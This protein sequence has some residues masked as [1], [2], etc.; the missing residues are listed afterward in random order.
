M[1]EFSVG[2]LELTPLVLSAPD[3]AALRAL[4]ATLADE[5]RAAG[6]LGELAADR[7]ARDAAERH[8]AVVLAADRTRLLDGLDALSSGRTAPSLVTGA[9]PSARR[10]VLVFPGAG[11][12]W[13]GM[14]RAL[15]DA[16]PPFARRLNAC[17]RALGSP[18]EVPDDGVDVVQ[19][20]LFAVMVSLAELWRSFGVEP[21]AVLAQCIGEPAGAYAGSALSLRD[22]A[23]A[24]TAM[25]EAQ[26]GVAALGDMAAVRL[27]APA[28]AAKLK[29]WGGRLWVAGVNAPEWTLV[30][31]DRAARD[32]LL[33]ALDDEG[34]FA[35]A[36]R[37]GAPTHTVRLD[38]ARTAMLD[39]LAAIT[40]RVGRVPFHSA[41]TGT[42]TDGALLDAGHW[43]RCVREPVRFEEATRSA[44]ADGPAALI[45]SAPHPSLL[46]AMRDTV[47]AAGADAVV[48]GSVDRDDGGLDQFTRSVAQAYCHGVAVDWARALA[49]AAP[50]AHATVHA[51]P[52]P[53]EPVRAATKPAATEA[54]ATERAATER[55]VAEPAVAEPAATEPAATEPAATEPAAT[56]PAAT[57]PAVTEPAASE[58]AMAEPAATEP[59][60]TEPAATE[61][62]EIGPAVAER[63]ATERVGD[64]ADGPGEPIAILGMACRFPG[65]IETPEQLWDAVIE[66][67]DLIGGLP[68]DRGWDTRK[69]YEPDSGKPGTSYTKEGGFLT[70]AAEFDAELFG[71]SPRE[72][73][74]MHPQQRILLEIAWEACER[75]GVD[76]LSLRETDTGVFIGAFAT[77]Y[78]PRMHEAGAGSSGYM[79]TGGTLSVLS[80]RIAYALGLMGPAMTID[81]ACSSSLTSVHQAVASLRSGECS[82][83]FA[84]GASVLG[85]PG[86][87]VDFSRQQALSHDGHSRAFSADAD[88]FGMA[89]GA[90]MLLL[91][92]LSDARRLGRPVLGV[93]R[94]SALSQDGASE[95]LAVPDAGAQEL[96]VRRALED[97]GLTAGDIDLVEAHGTGTKVGDPI[98]ARS[99]LAAYGPAGHPVFLGSVKSNIGHSMAAAGVAGVIKAV[100]ALRH[101][102][103]P[104]TLHAERLNPDVDWSRGDVRVLRENRDW[105][106]T[107]RVRR[108]AVSAYGISGT[109][110]HLVLEQ[111]PSER[112]AER[113]PEDVPALPWVLTARSPAALRAQAERLLRYVRENPGARAADVGWTLATSRARLEHRGVIV[114]DR[115]EL[116]DGLAALAAGTDAPQL[117]RGAD[118]HDAHNVF[119]FPGQGSQW[120]GMAAELLE[121]SPVFARRIAE[122][123]EALA[124][125]IDWSLTDVLRAG[126]PDDAGTDVVQPALF[127]VMVSLAA[128][129]EDHGVVPDAVLGHSQGEMAAAVVAGALSLA[130]AARVVALRARA[131]RVLA[132]TGAMA[133]VALPPDAA[134][135]RLDER[136]SVAAING[137]AEVVVSGDTDAVASLLE[138][139]EA[140]GVWARRIAVDFA[141]HS[142]HVERLRDRLLDDLDGVRPKT[143]DVPFYST[144]TGE[145]LD[146]E[147]LDAEYWFTNLRSPVR[148]DPALR[149]ALAAGHRTLIEISPHPILTMGMQ[150]IID[151]AG[152]DA[153]ALGTLRRGDGG[154]RRFRLAVAEADAHGVAAD[155]SRAFAGTAPRLL[156]LPTYAFQHRRYWLD[157]DA[158]GAAGLSTAGLEDAGHPLLG[159]AT[160]L[161]GSQVL[162]LTGSVS[163]R[164]HPFLADHAVHDAVVFPGTAF[165]EV[166]LQAADR[167]G[168]D[169]VEELILET[170]LVIPADEP[171]RL[172][173]TVDEDGTLE[174][175][176]RPESA[177]EWTRHATG[178]A[179]DPPPSDTDD[180]TAWPPSGAEPVPLDGFYD[181]VAERGYQYGPA[182]RNL[183]AAW[184]RGDEVFAEIAL[185]GDAETEAYALHPALLDAALQGTLLDAADGLRMPLSWQD[186]RLHA[187]G[188]TALRARLART[189]PDTFEVTVADA[190]GRP[191]LTVRSLALRTVERLRTTGAGGLFRLDWP[192]V[193][194][195]DRTAPDA[196]TWALVGDEE[197][198]GVLPGS[199]AVFPDVA[200]L[201]ASGAPDVAVL[202]C[203]RSGAHET[204]GHVLSELREWLRDEPPGVLVVLTRG[205]V[206]VHPRDAVTDLAQAAVWG[207]VRGAQPEHQ[208]RLVLIDLDEETSVASALD[209][210][211]PQIALR[212]GALHV[213]RL[214]PAKPGDAPDERP[215]RLDL[216]PGDP[217]SLRIVPADETPLGP[218]E[219]RVAVRAAGLNFRDVAVAGGLVER[220]EVWPLLG[221]DGAGVV[222]ATGPGV[223]DVAPGD[224]VAGA[225]TGTTA[226]ASTAVTD[227][228]LVVPIPDDWTFPEAA[229]VPVAFLTAWY[230]LADLAAL[231]PGEAVL[232]HAATGGVG[233]AAVQIAR[234]LGAE[235]FATASPAKHPALRALGLD[236]AHIASSRSTAFEQHFRATA[237]NVDVVLNCL[238]GDVIDAGLRLLAPGGRFVELGRTEL[239]D[240]DAVAREHPGVSYAAFDLGLLDP[241]RLHALFGDLRG[242]FEQDVLRPLPFTAWDVRDAREAFEHM[243]RAGHV[244]KIVLTVPRRPDPAGTVLIT[245]GTGALGALTARH[246]VTEHGLRHLL[247]VGRRGPD[248][249]GAEDLRAEL[250]ALG[251]EVTI[252]A[253]DA[254]DPA[255]LRRLLDGIPAEHPLTAVVHAAAVTD[256]G[257]V[258]ALTPG[259]IDRVL[260]P[261]ADAALNLHRLT[262]GSDLAA[263]VLY[264]SVASVVSTGGQA[265]YSAA[266]AFLD[267]LALRRGQHGL[268][269]T[270]VAWGL[271]ERASELTGRLADTDRARLAQNGQLPLSDRDGLALLDAALADGGP[272]FVGARLDAGALAG[273]P[274]DGVPA[275]L[276]RLVRPARAKAST[277]P[278]ET[279]PAPLGERLA[280]LPADDRVRELL[281]VVRAQ[282]ASVLGHSRADEID[283][284]RR[285]R[286]MGFDSL[287]AVQLRNHMNRLTELKL[288]TTLVFD[289]PT[290]LALAREI[291]VRLAERS[292][293]PAPA[294]DGTARLRRLGDEKVDPDE[295]VA[296]LREILGARESG[297]DNGDLA[298][299]PVRLSTGDAVP[300]LFCLPSILAPAE[301]DQY[302]EFAR[303][304]RGHR[305][306]LALT[307][308]G[309]SDGEPLPAT[310]D[311]FGRAA[312]RA[313]LAEA[314]D[315]PFVL[316][317]HSS[318]A[319]L[320]HAVAE[321]CEKD[322]RSPAGLVLLDPVDIGWNDLRAMVGTADRLWARMDLL[323]LLDDANVSAMMRY[324][325]LFGEWTPGALSCPV[326]ALRAEESMPGA[327]AGWARP[328]R[329]DRTPGDHL[330]MMTTRAATTARAAETWLRDPA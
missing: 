83:A 31:G 258:T 187:V 44:L 7:A 249:P 233:L 21:A 17:E 297:G 95:G 322:G 261:K 48:L 103:L 264:S 271:W 13:P 300:R 310:V 117:V 87:L 78:G 160:D 81:T 18:P 104:K 199:P 231:R 193:P 147:A 94:G 86:L 57:E 265:N 155:W 85:T 105:P 130:D 259:Q 326:L 189:G 153:V 293:G 112:P 164:T 54:A 262:R 114:G 221:F 37:T 276:R 284:D 151:D 171:V 256:D 304:F 198:R 232:I 319:W 59:A 51:D 238:T 234:H 60:V 33:A 52:V 158:P 223:T 6:D 246:L 129:W 22:A 169:G 220:H 82:L 108:A 45:E 257:V 119:V 75:S 170:P 141:S 123:A 140:E 161:A 99:L 268:P 188:A 38:G 263:F 194:P 312:A 209:T 26:A 146:T 272:F 308:P 49:P 3:A 215:W 109:N 324:A 305:D 180:L 315:A 196:R 68:D 36:V 69:L 212:G 183:R 200:A 219:I 182:F 309:F 96:A 316:V 245:G 162:L 211:E 14:G 25:A 301:P 283:A 226:F 149:A 50:S 135:E 116:L 150:E 70:D 139:L 214:V 252:A 327:D 10:P 172:Q 247:L 124:P 224:R 227:A 213:P 175:F 121:R 122:C 230:A 287:M 5:V 56:E 131:L 260:R 275:V 228:R 184:S 190:A 136:L 285:F 306:V 329:T 125:Y 307:L 290:P 174:I 148:F 58:R 35:T 266:N 80:G 206:A 203:P 98:E 29:R 145:L 47:R 253:C 1:N 298:V 216:E 4:A 328:G 292:G 73:T 34:V 40:P 192:V 74:A 53:A 12:Q 127:A 217:D 102:V 24:C 311:A 134:A 291:D 67:R 62:A 235:V 43:H 269:A 251:A 237:K 118:V 84:G 64:G 154:L 244:G 202:V 210:G 32:E 323:P 163:L 106:R 93:I 330:T 120:S 270:S 97:A 132:G 321:Q 165:L 248:A 107:D 239:R 16:S 159:A 317:G 133:T 113:A 243:R 39:R 41:T 65:G 289:H 30:S 201:R 205:A 299:R 178:A 186:V 28:L 156:D 303:F 19:P 77:E 101:G 128:V 254:A 100:L 142:A 274:E 177:P 110:A 294:D 72:A 207:A 242:L 273:R 2:R 46:T 126:V 218:G 15:R 167:A 8:R 63:A 152:T 278:A 166:A 27:A 325:E 197:A 115:A 89:E 179:G 111:S 20:A 79:L 137:P 240:A 296:L 9:A 88:G 225:F 288:P 229:T 143:S 255:A 76:P 176:S 236:D 71:I 313:V 61:R 185:T 282:A 279:D 241:A 91:A 92:R 281:G 11:C 42:E 222:E 286:E 138:E 302:G 250:T 90:G 191:V 314:G 208:G 295:K 168:F 144:V 157:A 66:G 173:A 320:A 204:V 267:G 277:R 195:A 318:G 280:A 55:A 181:R 23:L